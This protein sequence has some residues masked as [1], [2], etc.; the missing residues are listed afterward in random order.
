MHKNILFFITCLYCTLFLNVYCMETQNKFKIGF[1]FQEST[2]LCSWAKNNR[3]FQ[4]VP[5]LEVWNVDDNKL[6]YHIEIDGDD[7]EFVTRPF[8]HNEEAQL[9]LCII[10]IQDTLGVLKKLFCKYSSPIPLSKKQEN[11][12]IT[13]TFSEWFIELQK[14]FAGKSLFEGHLPQDIEQR[15]GQIQSTMTLVFP[16]KEVDELNNWS[17]I[18]APHVTIQHPLE[19]TIP[20]YLSLLGDDSSLIIA[21]PNKGA[22]SSTNWADFEEM[23]VTKESGLI[24][25]H[26]FTLLRMVPSS[27]EINRVPII[28][29]ISSLN[30]IAAELDS[31]LLKETKS[32]YI[33]SG[34]VD[35]K[36]RL[37]IMSRRP[38]SELFKNVVDPNKFYQG[39]FKNERGENSYIEAFSTAMNEYD[40]PHFENYMRLFSKVNYGEQFF[41]D[42]GKPINL[43]GFTELFTN[44]FRKN[45]EQL[46][47]ELLREGIITIVMIRNFDED[48][49]IQNATSKALDN[50]IVIDLFEGDNWYNLMLSTV[51][52]PNITYII[53]YKDELG[54]LAKDFLYDMLSPGCFMHGDDSMGR[55]KDMAEQ[56]IAFGEAIIEIR[57]I[58]SVNQWFLDLH[59]LFDTY[60]KID[61][62]LTYSYNDI[63]NQAVQLW[64]FLK[65]FNTKDPLIQLRIL[66]LLKKVEELKDV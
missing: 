48:I 36:G 21:L 43:I 64:K 34:Q 66:G 58:S 65:N 60:N 6:W 5:L 49:K 42:E 16:E 27:V 45:N 29:N 7:I 35:I 9:A 39:S 40:Y 50:P 18:F 56:D 25:L 33:S 4:K 62:F 10:S 2:H 1:E 63:S 32:Q 3:K 19:L 59:N 46:L 17:P 52:S 53:K 54:I 38:F 20:L 41:L 26:A 61:F 14:F 55:I 30:E 15:T 13:I 51:E 11:N 57:A 47:N 24:F 22:L 8:T 28:Q 31:E 37:L 44:T 23:C 12:P